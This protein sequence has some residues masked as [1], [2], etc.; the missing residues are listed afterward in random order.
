MQHPLR[1]QGSAKPS[2]HKSKYIGTDLPSH[3]PYAKM[4]ATQC[5]DFLHNAPPR[6][7]VYT[8]ESRCLSLTPPCP[9]MCK[10]SAKPSK[11]KS[12]YIGTDLPSHKPYAKKQCSGLFLN[13]VEADRYVVKT[14]K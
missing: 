9:L 8:S 2:K 11:H 4:L 10:G 12:K 13:A 1:G 5:F 6:V 3:K 7:S 14:L